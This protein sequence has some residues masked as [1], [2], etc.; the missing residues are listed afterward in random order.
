[1]QIK[2]LSRDKICDTGCKYCVKIVS[3]ML[4]LWKETHLQFS[5]VCLKC[6][7]LRPYGFAHRSVECAGLW[8][9]QV[10]HQRMEPG[11]RSWIGPEFGGRMWV[12]CPEMNSKRVSR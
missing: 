7:L 6:A 10:T 5:H 4:G 11:R 2:G 1:M 12:C 3:K 9:L 8:P